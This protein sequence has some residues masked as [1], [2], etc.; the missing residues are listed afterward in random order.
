F[1]RLPFPDDR[2]LVLSPRAQVPVEAVIRN[3]NP[4]SDEP[5]RERILPFKDLFP[6]LEP[7][8]FA[9]G[10]FPEFP[11]ILGRRSRQFL[12]LGK[13]GE[14]CMPC[15]GLIGR[16]DP[17]LPEDRGDSGRGPLLTWPFHVI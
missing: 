15:K 8:Q 2:R 6:P 16:K 7:M 13:R 10:I 12:V 4:P 11:G 5:F 14:L 9:R 1:P 3:I 17:L